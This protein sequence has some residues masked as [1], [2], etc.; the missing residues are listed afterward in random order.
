MSWVPVQ[1]GI[2]CT[3]CHIGR[4]FSIVLGFASYNT[5]NLVRYGIAY[6]IFPYCTG[7]HDITDKYYTSCLTL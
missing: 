2:Y 7:T 6:N 1:Y 3:L 5:R 4:D